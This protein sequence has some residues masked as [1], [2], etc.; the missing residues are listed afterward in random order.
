[1][2]Q[3][4]HPET[5]PNQILR[6]TSG[7]HHLSLCARRRGRA[8]AKVSIALCDCH[9]GVVECHL[10]SACG[11]V[12]RLRGHFHWTGVAFWSGFILGC[13]CFLGAVFHCAGRADRVSGQTADRPSVAGGRL[14]WAQA[15][16]WKQSSDAHNI[17]RFS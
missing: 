14:L 8:R 13:T 7:C 6:A 10:Y 2:L 15:A 17:R 5:L 4:S 12:H 1:L 11:T 9:A 3:F 16:I